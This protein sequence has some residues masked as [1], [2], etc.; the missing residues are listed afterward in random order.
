MRTL[1]KFTLVI[2]LSLGFN[3]YGQDNCS[4]QQMIAKID[5]ISKVKNIE[6][7]I[8]KF[9]RVSSIGESTR[10]ESYTLSAKRV[11]KFDGPFLVVE[12]SYF[13]MDKLLFF[14]VKED[15]IEFY[16]QGY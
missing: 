14:F 16:F 3:V 13:N 4:Y 1:K 12:G 5:S 9:Y 8:I 2:I 6:Q 15:Y 11:Y 7:G 10:T